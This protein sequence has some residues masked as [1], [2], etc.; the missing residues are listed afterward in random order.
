MLDRQNGVFLELSRREL[1]CGGC[2]S[3]ADLAEYRSD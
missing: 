2:G 3:P 1:V